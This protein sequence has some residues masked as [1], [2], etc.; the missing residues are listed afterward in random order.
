MPP[1]LQKRQAAPA[2]PWDMC[3]F[4]TSPCRHT[5]TLHPFL[6]LLSALCYFPKT[7]IIF[8]SERRLKPVGLVPGAAEPCCRTVI[9]GDILTAAGERGH[10]RKRTRAEQSLRWPGCS[11]CTPLARVRGAGVTTTVRGISQTEASFDWRGSISYL[12]ASGHGKISFNTV[13]RP[14]ALSIQQPENL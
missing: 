3:L 6:Y 13:C 12:N 8:I 14:P 7:I 11:G 1:Q 9:C 4:T 5:H 2:S 10:E